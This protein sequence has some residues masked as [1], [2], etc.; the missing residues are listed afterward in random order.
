MSKLNNQNRI[1]K[2]KHSN[3]VF[4]NETQVNRIINLFLKS[5]DF[6]YTCDFNLATSERARITFLEL[7]NENE[8]EIWDNHDQ[9]FKTESDLAY[10]L[11]YKSEY[12][13]KNCCN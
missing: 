11:E 1:E 7:K 6:K 10:F 12:F 8:S 2:Y 9:F 3:K 13:V 5:K 4:K